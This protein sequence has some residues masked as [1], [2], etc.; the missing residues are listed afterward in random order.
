M[1]NL[2][3]IKDKEVLKNYFS[4]L[5]SSLKENDLME[6]PSQIRDLILENCQ[7]THIFQIPK[8]SLSTKTDEWTDQVSAFQAEPSRR[9]NTG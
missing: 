9:Y 1:V 3:A 5:K 6:K 7:F 8:F 4:L 2:D